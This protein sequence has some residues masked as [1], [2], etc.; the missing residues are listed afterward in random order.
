[1]P[2]DETI[3]DWN[4][5]IFSQPENSYQKQIYFQ[6]IAEIGGSIKYYQNLKNALVRANQSSKIT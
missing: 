2:P 3:T 4:G 1:M 6:S 5:Y